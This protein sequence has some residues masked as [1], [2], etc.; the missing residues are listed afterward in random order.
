[1]TLE[2]D[3]ALVMDPARQDNTDAPFKYSLI[4]VPHDEAGIRK[5]LEDYKAFRLFSLQYAPEAFGSTYARELAFEDNVWYERL[6]NPISNTF[7]AIGEAGQVVSISTVNGPLAIGICD[8]PPLGIPQAAY[9]GWD[10]ASPL[11]FRLNAIF[12]KPEARRKRISKALVETSIKYATDEA[13]AKGKGAVFSII[14][15]TDNLPAKALYESVGFVAA[16]RLSA[17]ENVYGCPVILLE[18]RPS[19]EA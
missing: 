16:M 13:K 5:Y 1:V 2:V 19:P 11:H 14:V 12:T 7:M 10:G 18:Y 9:G 17:S 15:D 8:M 4:H 3:Q 6:R